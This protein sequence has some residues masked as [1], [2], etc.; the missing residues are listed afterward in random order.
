VGEGLEPHAPGRA[1]QSEQQITAKDAKDC[2]SIKDDGRS[3]FRS[4]RVFDVGLQSLASLAVICSFPSSAPMR[5][6][7]EP[8][9]ST[10]RKNP[11]VISPS[12]A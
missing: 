1:G 5:G 12:I 9:T 4:P 3:L 2:P 10:Q 6:A 7:R 8:P 11:K